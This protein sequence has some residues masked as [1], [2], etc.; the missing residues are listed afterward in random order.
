MDFR[1]VC[2]LGV[3]VAGIFGL[4]FLL[5]PE[6][7]SSLYGISGWNPGTTLIARL[8]GGGL[9]FTASAS[10]AVKGTLDPAIQRTFGFSFAVVSL[11][12]AAISLQS[13]TSGGTNALMWSTVAIFAAF[14][15]MWFL[16]AR[17]ARVS[18]GAAA[19]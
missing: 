4:G 1:I 2:V 15:V 17:G 8:Y 9:L 10:F 18:S 14:A 7:V 19:A 6:L 13:V 12:G 11:I 5:L 3:V 16:A